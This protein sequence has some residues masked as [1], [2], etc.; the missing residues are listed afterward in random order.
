MPISKEKNERLTRVGPGTL[1][2]ELLRR[3]WYPVAATSEMENRYTNSQRRP[4][5]E[6]EPT[7]SQKAMQ[8][9]APEVY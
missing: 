3:Y 4:S 8:E 7:T 1:G 9:T 5:P 6:A 2:G